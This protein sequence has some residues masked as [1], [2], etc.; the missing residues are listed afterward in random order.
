MEFYNIP[1]EW[2][3]LHQGDATKIDQVPDNTHILIAEHLNHG[4]FSLE[5]LHAV[6]A[7]LVP[8][9]TEPRIIIPKGVKVYGRIV[10][11]EKQVNNHD[12]CIE[13][14]Q[15]VIG[16][17][18]LPYNRILVIDGSQYPEVKTTK[19][20]V[21]EVYFGTIAF[22]QVLNGG[23]DGTVDFK[24][25]GFAIDSG[26]GIIEIK[27]VPLF[28]HEIENSLD[29]IRYFASGKYPGQMFF[30]TSLNHWRGLIDTTLYGKY[31]RSPQNFID[32]QEL[33]Q[34]GYCVKNTFGT[35]N[36]QRYE[37]LRGAVHNIR[38]HGPVRSVSGN[39]QVTHYFA[40]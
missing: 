1:Q 18:S 37:I 25:E 7:N 11:P 31:Q 17:V 5:P 14:Y 3:D 33:G 16:N 9:L 28:H 30:G 36:S 2:Y 26:Q 20:M 13:L 8:K 39:S 22:E 34:M 10:D 35:H 12:Y 32:W 40:L 27:I 21:P 29:R 15:R 24:G 38:V 6:H 19:V 23:W 4:L